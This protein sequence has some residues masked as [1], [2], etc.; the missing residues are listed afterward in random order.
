MKKNREWKQ[1]GRRYLSM[2]LAVGMVV[3]L[4]ACGP[5]KQEEI[6]PGFTFD[7][8]KEKEDGI[9]P[10]TGGSSEKKEDGGTVQTSRAIRT[11]EY[12]EMAQYPNYDDFGN[13]WN[14]YEEAMSTWRESRNSLR[15]ENEDYKA[16]LKEFCTATIKEFIGTED[17][18]NKVYSP[19]NVYMALAML[20]E[21]TD[22]ESRAQ[23][24]NLMQ[25]DTIETLRNKITDIWKSS[26]SDDGSVTTLL[27]NSIWLRQGISYVEETMNT[28]QEVYY[29]SSYQ[30][31]MGSAEYNKM[32]QDWLNEQTGGLLAEQAEGV[33]MNPETIMAIASTL[34]FKASWRD[35]FSK[36]AT[37]E[38][39]FHAPGGDMTCEFMKQ[40]DDQTVYGGDNFTAIAKSFNN[41]GSMFLF[42]P[43]EGVAAEELLKDADLME[44]IFN[45]YEWENQKHMQVNLELPK[46]DVVS[47]LSLI[48]GLKN[49]GVTD[50]FDYTISDFTPMTT[51]VDA[52]FVSQALHAARV[53]ID[54][55]GCE[56]AAYTVMTVDTESMFMGDEI[57]LVFDRPFVF[58]ITGENGLPLFTGVV[59]QPK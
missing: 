13:D 4:A 12:P 37:E 15:P 26:Y 3:S 56:A 50:V 47:D 44:L 46:F 38:K 52:L 17:G 5:E 39:T 41:S 22:G 29:A 19:I 1:C 14:K 59:N 6:D 25:V 53:K 7:P 16:G 30:G 28:L 43:D 33:E 45:R 21:V 55:E 10:Q 8:E 40:S 35:E 20:A 11:V 54:E 18:K 24:L 42:L 27:G 31:Q 51:D 34:Y 32:L 36:Y 58:V 57:T 49:L 9:M 2:L 23:I 48:N